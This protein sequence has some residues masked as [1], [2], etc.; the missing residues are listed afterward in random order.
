M[1]TYLRQHFK[2][3]VAVRSDGESLPGFSPK[4]GVFRHIF[5]M[6]SDWYS[7]ESN[8]LNK[9]YLIYFVIQEIWPIL[10][11]FVRNSAFLTVS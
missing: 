9:F 8:V 5:S 1:L 10:V 11:V 3:S 4:I 6:I 7:A 2:N